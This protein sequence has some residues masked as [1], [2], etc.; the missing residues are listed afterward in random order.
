V[1]LNNADIVA[2]ANAGNGG[3]IVV[4][5]GFF[6]ASAESAVDAS[7]SRGLDGE[8]L[9]DS[10]NEI[11]G[12]VLPLEVPAAP[13]P[14]LI[15]QNCVPQLAER[16]SSLTVQTR[17]SALPSPGDY[18]PSPWP[19]NGDDSPSAAAAPRA[20]PA[21]ASVPSVAAARGCR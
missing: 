17:S 4:Q 9:I 14:A 13:L 3:N 15:T 7:S 1:I 10:P 18:L 19:T 16:R 11:A 12:S 5:A 20:A 2:R 21:F 6:V 8:V